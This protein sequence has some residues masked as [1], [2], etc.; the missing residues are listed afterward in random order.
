[1][2]RTRREAGVQLVLLAI[3]VATLIFLIALVTG[4][5]LYAASKSRFQNVANLAALAAVE[6]LLTEPINSKDNTYA[7][8]SN[9]AVL[10][11]SAILTQNK[12]PGTL[13][14][15]SGVTDFDAAPNPNDSGVIQFGRWFNQAPKDQTPCEDIKKK[16]PCFVPVSDLTANAVQ[17]RLRTQVGNIFSAPF[18][19]EAPGK[20]ETSVIGTVSERCTAYV[21][22]TSLSTVEE[23][24]PRCSAEDLDIQ[25]DSTGFTKF[26]TCKGPRKTGYF[27]YRRDSVQK[28]NGVKWVD[29]DCSNFTAG[30]D[31]ALL[32]G[33]PLSELLHFCL[34]YSYNTLDRGTD[35]VD[36]L[37]AD[38]NTQVHYRSD[39]RDA[40]VY[41]DGAWV[42]V[43]VDT[44][45]GGDYRGPEPLRRFMLAFNASLREI[46]RRSSSADMAFVIALDGHLRN[47]FP[48]AGLSSELG[49][50]VQLTNLDNRGIYDRNGNSL[51]K[52][53][54]GT[55]MDEIH[56]NLL[57]L[58]WVPIE[59]D[60]VHAYQ[61]ETNLILGLYRAIDKLDEHC[62]A[63]SLKNIILATDGLFTCRFREGENF[64]V[65][66]CSDK[67]N[68]EMKK[69]SD[70]EEGEQ[71][72]VGGPKVQNN[73]KAVLKLLQDKDIALTTLLDGEAIDPNFLNIRNPKVTVCADASGPSCFYTYQ[74]ARALGYGGFNALGVPS[75]DAAWDARAPFVGILPVLP[76]GKCGTC[77]A[78][79]KEWWAKQRA[80]QTMN[81]TKI[82]FR[83]P[84]GIFSRL[85]MDS[86]G[87]F[88]PLLPLSIGRNTGG[89]ASDYY[90]HDNDA[91]TP[92]ILV[93]RSEVRPVD[94]MNMY[95][96]EMSSKSEQAVSCAQQAVG[97]APYILVEEES[98]LPAS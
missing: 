44:Y 53:V 61:G 97:G 98:Y 31:V 74:L 9:Q 92:D 19:H 40:Q 59:K 66:P 69:L 25:T 26:P 7:Y 82:K 24:H 78:E 46:K 77:T 93:N 64:N 38:V 86:G 34:M 10:R 62:P 56:P 28:F 71:W 52:T 55:P 89:L 3:F 23:T 22:D 88:C 39:Y 32:T 15:L 18:A 76:A 51:L 37:N 49:R 87:I 60:A 80:G 4:I 1:M 50:M 29:K 6:T 91:S 30:S 36:W 41:I 13:S 11:A 75:T 12:L 17:L 94:E 42:D 33:G 90:N 16:Y 43:L 95:S 63:R 2:R 35:G 58:G 48:A 54:N 67:G 96:Y 83:R 57:D 20:L 45:Y 65:H 47:E 84:N 79:E 8:R 72:L 85:S 73:K 21:L 68:H 27:I 5:G 70:Y 14:V 81:G